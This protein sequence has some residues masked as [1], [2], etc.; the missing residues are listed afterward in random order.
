[1]HRFHHNRTT[2]GLAL[3]I[4]YLSIPASA[5]QVSC[6]PQRFLRNDFEHQVSVWSPD[7]SRR[8]QLRKNFK[9]RV[10][11]GGIVIGE[12]GL[13]DDPFN[14]A[15]KWSSDSRSFYVEMS[16]DTIG[17]QLVAYTVIGHTLLK[18]KGPEVVAR[19]FEEKH[20]CKARDNN[21]HAVRW[22]DGSGR[23]L[24]MPEVYNSTDCGDESGYREGFL[25]DAESGKIVKQYPQSVIEA[26]W[27]KCGPD[28]SA[29]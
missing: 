19:E 18:L 25:V 6:Q 1:M 15:I 11:S 7:Q 27:K 20:S 5:Q 17:V 12:F 8:V 26:E 14:T 22:E 21:L 24:L 28:E 13:V 10:E 4:C 29:R 3:L 23:L 16:A 2:A 9:L